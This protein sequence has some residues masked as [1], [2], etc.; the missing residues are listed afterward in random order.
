M[1]ADRLPATISQNGHGRVGMEPR[2]YGSRPMAV[3][4]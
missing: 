3:G 4:P 1:W 2:A